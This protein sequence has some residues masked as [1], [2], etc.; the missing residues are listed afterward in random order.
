M[1]ADPA[2][3]HRHLLRR[4]EGWHHQQGAVKGQ[5]TATPRHSLACQHAGGCVCE[6][7]FLVSETSQHGR[8]ALHTCLVAAQLPGSICLW[9]LAVASRGRPITR[10]QRAAYGVPLIGALVRLQVSIL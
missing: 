5:T 1:L 8:M 2:G 3:K 6:S 4:W 9:R 7:L 10:A